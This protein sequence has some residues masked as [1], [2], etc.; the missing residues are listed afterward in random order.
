M[1]GFIH[2]H[3]HSTFSFYAGVDGIEE[4]V[5]QAKALKMSALALTDTDSMSGLIKFYLAC[6]KEGI[7]PIL[8][9]E[10]TAPQTPG[11][12]LVLLARDE[13]GYRD[14]C[15]IITRRH[16]QP[17]S[18]S[19]ENTLNRPWPHLF[20]ITAFPS[21]LKMAARTPNH[22][23]LYGEL[24]NQCR[25]SR[26]RSRQ[27]ETLAKQL[28]IPLTASNNIYFRTPGDREIHRVLRSIGLL[29]TVSRLQP[30][31][32]APA[33]AFFASFEE[34]QK[35]FP[36]HSQALRNSG[37]IARECNV[38]LSLG[39]WIMP[40]IRVPRGYSPRSYLNKLAREGL[41]RNY[42]GRRGFARAKRIQEMELAVISR[43]GYSSYF[44]M[45]KQIRDWANRRFQSGYRRPGDC[46]ILRGSAANSITFYN[47]GV[48]SLDPIRYDLYFQRFLNEERASPPDADLDFGW[49][50]RDRVLD[51][52]EKT[53]GRDR[54]AMVGTTNHFRYR[55]AFRE[56]A[57]V[58]GYTEEQISAIL[59]SHRTVT[60]R[61]QDDEIRHLMQIARRIEG[62]P[63][64]L[65]QHP[66]GVLVTNDPIRRHVACQ[67]SGGIKNRIIT[68]IDMHNGIDELGLIKFDILGNGSLSVL[69]DT[70]QLVREQKLPDPEVW[71]QEK[72]QRD[73][74]VCNVI[75]QGRTK[76]I[77]YI[78][79]PAQMRLNR[80]V[81]AETFAE[82][83]L[84]SSL[85]RP[86]GTPY[87]NTFVER[88]RK[89]KQGIRDWDFL[90]PALKPIL[91]ES[92][93]V[94]AFQEDITKICH[95][96]AGLNYRQADRIRKMM[97]SLHEGMLNSR[98]YQDTA[99]LFI[100]GCIRHR[101]LTPGQARE[102]WKRVSSFTGFSFC[103]SHS[104]SYAQLS[105]KCTYL[106]TCYP[107]QFFAAVISN[108]HGFYTVDAYL[109]EARRWGL[110]I[111]PIDIN[112]SRIAFHGR[113]DWLRPGFMHIRNLSL[114]SMENI[115]AA[116][117]K[118]GPFSGL[119]DFIR[120]TPV[121][122]KEIEHLI[123]VGAFDCL[124][125]SRPHLLFKLDGIYGASPSCFP[126]LFNQHALTPPSRK[127]PY[128][129]D[130]SLMEKCLQ[131]QY[132][133]GYVISTNLL[134]V[135]HL[136]PAAKDAVSA[137]S[138][139][140]FKNRRVKVFGRRITQRGHVVQKSGR[141]MLFLTLEDQTGCID[142][143]FWPDRY[144]AFLDTIQQEGP[145]VIQGTVIEEWGTFS[146]QADT[147]RRVEWTP[148]LAHDP[149]A[150]A[151]LQKTRKESIPYD[152]IS[153]PVA[154]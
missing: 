135:F 49:D 148:S 24:I 32:Q 97:N 30:S 114:K 131:E 116:R 147:I 39:K 16:L 4:L 17:E 130:Y 51:Y 101:G 85:V 79:S 28:G 143:I 22:S 95:R 18:F 7:K 105:F 13:E 9:T 25:N 74:R 69:R 37:R 75:R 140:Q 62:K 112:H 41:A 91:S 40:E 137:V 78:E 61:I 5:G 63:R 133:L 94:C 118:G 115:L 82:V 103:K 15:E 47:I 110:R 134:A 23:R 107:A 80:K 127:A 26:R 113:D 53:W 139:P 45:V 59:K 106:K 149:Q 151:L 70:L 55:A 117:A 65:G 136:H 1:T 120:R 73:R 124:D 64:F 104:A 14:I 44:L 86:A 54:V 100:R 88:H 141:N 72:C 3:C 81:Q 144:E 34:M 111:L 50:E 90:H 83:T 46:S 11:E 48:S 142:V 21:L 121:L 20:F 76:G 36:R 128:L 31:E 60:R 38:H 33:G 57:K 27:L 42:G 145:F 125:I 67:Y 92:H 96:V 129:S 66:G 93:D 152:D 29:T 153:T 77:F 68:Q 87:I 52:M 6:K 122:R 154:V 132:L 10:L 19:L 108:R 99:A 71:N 84:T 12:N 2:L 35:R 126:L 119:E 43:L 109:Q 102:L 123:L 89:K 58:Y 98:E 146:L 150:D 8:G 56:T 138:L